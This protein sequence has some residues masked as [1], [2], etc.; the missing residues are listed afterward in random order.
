M[1]VSINRAFRDFMVKIYKPAHR[2]SQKNH[3]KFV[4]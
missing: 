2:N 1:Y 4:M 3:N